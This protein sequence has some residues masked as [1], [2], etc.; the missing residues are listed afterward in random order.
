M[1][2]LQLLGAGGLFALIASVL[3]FI[4]T[5]KKDTSTDSQARF[6][7][8]IELNKYLDTKVTAAL[9]PALVQIKALEDDMKILTARERATK[10][11]VRRFFQRLMFWNEQGRTG[12]MPMPTRED[13]GVLDISDL[14]IPTAPIEGV[15]P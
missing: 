3:T 2:W 13:M 5:R 1:E 4:A 10:E 8:N 7:A 6:E 14:V 15:T 11:I 12:I 9:A